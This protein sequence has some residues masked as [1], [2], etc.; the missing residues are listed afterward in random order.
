MSCMLTVNLKIHKCL[1]LSVG[2]QAELQQRLFAWVLLVDYAKN[3]P[4]SALRKQKAKVSS[5]EY[6][7]L[8]LSLEARLH[9][10]SEGRQALTVQSCPVC[11][12]DDVV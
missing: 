1:S 6:L 12:S 4:L 10:G 5:T 3:G 8:T 7:S 2:E 11:L 9:P